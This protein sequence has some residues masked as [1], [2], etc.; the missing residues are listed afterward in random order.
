MS[1][2]HD[3]AHASASSESAPTRDDSDPGRASRT[4]L[5]RKPDV[6]IASGLVQRKARDANGVADGAD[7]AV[8]AASSS[9]G[10]SLPAT[11][12]RKFESSLGADLSGVRV[13][14]GDSSAAAND[15]VG[16]KAYTTGNDIHFGAGHYDPSSKAGEHLLAHEVAHTVQQSG[17]AQRMQFKLEVSS[18]D[19]A[20]EHEADRAADAMVKGA[21][22]AVTYGS[23]VSRKIMRESSE[24]QQWLPAKSV[25]S[26]VDKEGNVA[27]AKAGELPVANVPTQ[28]AKA[29]ADHFDQK[30]RELSSA[31]IPGVTKS[32]I[33]NSVASETLKAQKEGYLGDVAAI[34]NLNSQYNYSVDS[35]NTGARALARNL[36]LRGALGFHAG[37]D[38][39]QSN[40]DAKQQKALK[41]SIQ[42]HPEM[43]QG[44]ANL[45]LLA[46]DVDSNRHKLNA[47]KLSYKNWVIGTVIVE[48]QA[49]LKEATD[50]KTKI[51]NNI[52]LGGQIASGVVAAVDMVATGGKWMDG[53]AV[54]MNPALNAGD[55]SAKGVAGAAGTVS[56]VGKSLDVKG[57]TEFGMQ[58]Y[59][60]KDL[61][62]LNAKITSATST[63]SGMTEIKASND[64]VKVGED[65]IGAKKAYVTS[66]DRLSKAVGDRRK[67][68]A[69]IAKEADE[70]LAPGKNSD[71]VSQVMLYMSSA[72]ETKALLDAGLSAALSAQGYIDGAKGQLAKHRG[73]NYYTA[74]SFYVPLSD[75]SLAPDNAVMMDLNAALKGWI[76]NTKAEKAV[77]D[78]QNLSAASLM[79]S[80]GAGEY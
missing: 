33:Q 30:L 58:L 24:Y 16:A 31:T 45:D 4:A 7:S 64:A 62:E 72:R 21:P 32:E 69:A 1:H 39:F 19:D 56:S 36:K 60:Q 63:I 5:M 76:A 61:D 77:L 15:A 13:H 67:A 44:S 46:A 66:C 40:L 79:G 14:T 8:A 43:L 65:L 52:K 70:S 49:K 3:Q 47:A 10:S 28:Y 18:P 80:L 2:D 20:F 23:G 50:E 75:D 74:Q 53:K 71:A 54:S 78:E 57:L 68:Y 22:A 48:L 55:A 38:V 37:K 73:K 29:R 6:A 59:Y 34:E 9:S 26:A 35:A 42:K 51:E 11:L 12:Q 41:A 17:G 25:T 27:A